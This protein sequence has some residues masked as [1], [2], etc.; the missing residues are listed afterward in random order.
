MN[1]TQGCDDDFLQ[2]RSLLR[3]SMLNRGPT[4]SIIL[5]IMCFLPLHLRRGGNM[6]AWVMATTL[7][8]ICAQ[9]MRY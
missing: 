1:P 5:Q 3:L 8:L 9:E 7:S 4:S 6:P 2:I